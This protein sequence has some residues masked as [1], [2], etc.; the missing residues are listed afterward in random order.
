MIILLAEKCTDYSTYQLEQIGTLTDVSP[1]D[2]LGLETICL[3]NTAGTWFPFLSIYGGGTAGA[4]FT[5]AF[6][7]PATTSG[8]TATQPW[9]III[10]NRRSTNVQQIEDMSAKPGA[11][12]TGVDLAGVICDSDNPSTIEVV[13]EEVSGWLYSDDI[14]IDNQD[15]QSIFSLLGRVLIG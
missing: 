9:Q 11:L 15:D 8:A 14:A 12:T 13:S 4:L 3:K 6:R 10:N 2:W 7:V 1:I 5:A